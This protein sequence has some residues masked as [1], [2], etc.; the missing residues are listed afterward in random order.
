MQ[1]GGCIHSC[2]PGGEEGGKEAD[3]SGILY[4]RLLINI[5]LL[6]LHPSPALPGYTDYV[7][8]RTWQPKSGAGRPGY[9]PE[10]F[11]Q[12]S[13]QPDIKRTALSWLDSK[14][15]ESLPCGLDLNTV[16]D[17]NH[18][19]LKENFIADPSRLFSHAFVDPIPCT[20]SCIFMECFLVL[21]QVGRLP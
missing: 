14:P 8:I 12:R 16:R 6:A 10:R 7:S 20:L 1:A 5:A 13:G 19:Q 9:K 11:G 2:T 3:S 4:G 18:E 17:S 15:R 21:S